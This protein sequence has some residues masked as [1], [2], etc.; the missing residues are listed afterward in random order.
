MGK[1]FEDTL[2]GSLMDRT[3]QDENGDVYCVEH[4]NL[5]EGTII[6]SYADKP[7]MQISIAECRDHI[8]VHPMKYSKR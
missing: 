5:R 3:F 4:V 7:S 2:N 6:A 1:N 8:L